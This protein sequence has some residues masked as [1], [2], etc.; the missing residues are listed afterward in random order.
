MW[1]AITFIVLITMIAEVFKYNIKLK[2]QR[3]PEGKPINND[4]LER[5]ERRIESLETIIID[6][7]KDQ[8]FKDLK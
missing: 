6:L 3:A 2:N 7:E 5:L 1:T 4:K 8:R